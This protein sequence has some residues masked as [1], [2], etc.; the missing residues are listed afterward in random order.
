MQKLLK[1]YQKVLSLGN[2]TL[3]KTI[4]LRNLGIDSRGIYKLV[5]NGYLER[6]RQ[7]YY[8]INSENISEAETIKALFSDGVICMHT[9]LFYYGYS[10][11]TPLNWDIAI[12]RNV[13][14]SRFNVDYP[15][16]KPYYMEKAHLEY[17]I[18]VAEY[19]GTALNIFDRDRLICECIKHENKIDKETYN[20][21]I[22]GYINDTKKSIS[23]LLEYARKRNVLNK[24][25]SRI[26]VWL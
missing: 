14:K 1:N 19:D 12:D 22:Q 15:Y 18:S 9:A 7:G 4:D 23:N 24:V 16:V 10:D 13:S 17:G 26:E 25:K 20:K 11:R 21:A 6:V 2:Q 5:E 8:K 3:I